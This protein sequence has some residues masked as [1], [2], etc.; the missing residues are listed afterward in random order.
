LRKNI[1]KRDGEREVQPVHGQ[2]LFHE[3]PR[4]AKP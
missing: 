4:E 3:S 1:V 2:C